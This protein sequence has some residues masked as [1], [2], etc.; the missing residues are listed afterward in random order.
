MSTGFRTVIPMESFDGGLNNKYEPQ[1]IAD[2]EAQAARNV[3]FD[4]LGGVET[5]QGI[6]L[7]NTAAVNSNACDGL[8]TARWNSGNQSMIAFFGSDMFVLSGTTFQTV[9]SAQGVFTTGTTKY[10]QMYQNVMFF[11]HGG[12]PYKYDAN[13]GFYRHGIE[14]PSSPADGGTRTSG[15]N[16]IGSYNY[17]V[18]YVNTQVVEGN[19][20]TPSATL[21]ASAGGEQML[22]TGIPVPPASY[23][24]NSKYLYRNFANSGANGVYYFLTEIPASATTYTDNIA[25]SALGSEAPT[26]NGKPPNY[27]VVKEHQERLFFLDPQNPQYLFYSELGNPYTVKSINFM[28]IADG[29]GEKNVG[30]AIQ[31][32]GIIVL[33]EDSIWAIEMPDTDPASWRKKRTDAKYGCASH[34]SLVEFENLIMFLGQQHSKITGFLAILGTSVS[35]QDSTVTNVSLDATVLTNTAII[36][37]SKSDRIEPDVFLFQNSLKSKAFAIEFDNK[38]WC[39]VCYGTGATENNRIY[40]FDFMRRDKARSSGSWIPFTGINANAM[41]VYQGNLYLGS[42]LAD[43]KVHQAN[44]GMYNDNGSAIDS[45]FQTKEFD[46]GNKERYFDKDFRHANFTVETLG[47]WQMRFNWFIDSERG[48]GNSYDFSLNPGGSL[49]GS[50]LVFGIALWGGGNERT[51]AKVELGQAIGKRISFKFSNMNTAN[52]G[53]KVVR[54]NVYYNRRG[55]R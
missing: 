50:T 23:G 36:S 4:A 30:L 27:S 52:Q 21:V 9:P 47:D 38:I 17:K 35:P 20:G 19:V 44:N 34:N 46:G 37:D 22:L 54:G 5:R 39:A 15:G 7:V 49:W 1:I 48:A 25:S 2:N 3:V 55:L 29:D 8:F 31:S 45:Y 43:G 26:D 41:T 6:T 53:F 16:L 12:T 33:K 32:N 13:G 10:N 14:T 40:Q 28:K 42:S 51:D 18:S 11:G 24:V